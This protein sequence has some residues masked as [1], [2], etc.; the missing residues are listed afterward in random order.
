MGLV[1]LLMHAPGASCGA[2][3]VLS[4]LTNQVKEQGVSSL[5]G[6]P[7]DLGRFVP[8]LQ[9]AMSR[10]YVQDKHGHYLM[11]GFIH[12]FSLGVDRTKLFGQRIFS[13]YPAALAAEDSVSDA[14][15]SRLDRYKSLCLGA[16]SSA[17]A[18]LRATFDSFYVFPMGAAAKASG[19]MRPTSD[20]SRTGLNAA[21]T[22]G[23]LGH[24]LDAHRQLQ[25]LLSRNAWMAVADIE[26]AFSYIPL[27]PWLWP[28]MFFRWKRRRSERG[29]DKSL[30]LYVNLF[31]DFGTRGAP[32]TFKLILV[33]VFLGMA[34]SEFVLT[35][36]MVVYVDDV[37]VIATPDDDSDEAQQRANAQMEIFQR[38]ITEFTGLMWKLS[39]QL[40]AAQVQLYIGFWWNTRTFARSLPEQKVVSYL[41]LLLDF[42]SRASAT[43]LERQS[44]A[45]KM[46]R[47]IMTL[48]P[49][50]ACLLVNCYRMMSGLKF[51][52][53]RKRTSRAERRDYRFVHDLLKYNQGKGYYS[54]DG[55]ARGPGFRSDASKSRALTAGGWVTED[56]FYDWFTYGSSAARKPI[57]YLEGDT[58]LRCCAFN[59]QR[60]TGQLIHGEIDNKAFEL[61]AE[62]GR[63]RAERLNNLLRNLFILQLRYG[64]V[65][66]TSWISS[67][68][69]DLAD[70]LSRDRL[71][72]FLANA[73]SFVWC[74]CELTRHPEAG[75]VVTLAD[76]D[77]HDS[78]VDL[79]SLIQ[80]YSADCDGEGMHSTTLGGGSY[81]LP[82]GHSGAHDVELSLLPRQRR[83]T[84]A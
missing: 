31:A 33:D 36:P 54:Y 24:S 11:E 15:E 23:I 70:D 52:W 9:R 10:G 44:L 40:L 19:A 60:W 78:V 27:A 34:R 66:L 3:E 65:L 79:Q 42:S 75:R 5:P 35:L 50:A 67:E 17:E 64:F 46:Q 59:A 41:Q 29:R 28:F 77:Y 18:A 22:L 1:V 81:S 69:N 13:N 51:G 83:T 14:I 38:W 68:D 55:F 53:Q 63:S 12:G 72:R 21:S 56:G 49:G 20:H 8:I 39:K 48:P 76:K 74:G 62:A 2:I 82:H 84:V 71:E 80:D 7:M 32:G 25:Y 61:S 4:G 6:C 16:W 57:D 73:Y 30:Y 45:G 26:D 47:V 58:A 37:G 43:L